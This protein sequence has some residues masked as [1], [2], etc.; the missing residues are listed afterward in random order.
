MSN[1]GEPTGHALVGPLRWTLLDDQ[2]VVFSSAAGT[3]LCADALA[4]AICALLEDGPASSP[5]LA[6]RLAV[7]M[8]APV[9][10]ALV[11]RISAV[12]DELHDSGLVACPDR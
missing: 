2:W 5:S 6:E 3:L 4:A 8:Q 11:A 10:D 12:L 9:S 7:S 1:W